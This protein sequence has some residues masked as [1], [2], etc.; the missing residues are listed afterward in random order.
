VDINGNRSDALNIDIP[1]IQGI[2]W[3]GPRSG[4]GFIYMYIWFGELGSNLIATRF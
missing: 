2:L 4:V 3:L 1:V